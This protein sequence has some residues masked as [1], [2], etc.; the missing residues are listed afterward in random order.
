MASL[1]LLAPS[2]AEAL[3][4]QQVGGGFQQPIYVTSDPGDA[5]RLLVVER[6]GTIELVEAGVTSEFADLSSVVSCCEG[7]RGLLSIALDPNF[8]ATGRL[9]VDYTGK[10]VPGEIHVAELVAGP[11]RRTAS[12]STLKPLLAIP[13]PTES[14]H[15]GG[16]LQFGPDGNLYMSTGDGGGS[17][18]Q[19]HNAQNLKK[20]LGKI[21]RIHPNPNGPAPFYT[22]PAGNPFAASAGDYAPI[23]SYGLRN[24][25]RFSFDRLSGDMVIGDVGQ[26]AREEI[27]LA[28]SPR[29]GVVGG[30][31]ANY[32]W[33]CR[34][35]F[36]AGPATDPECATPPPAGLVE[37]V[38][39]YPHTPDPDLG[40]T[41]ERCA[42]IGGYVVRDRSLGDLYGRYLYG[43][44]CA[45]ELRS[46]DLAD[47][48][49]SDRSENVEATGLNSFGED[50]CGRIYVVEGSGHVYRLSGSTPAECATPAQVAAP[51]VATAK[52]ATPTFI[53][54]KPQRRRV[55]RGKRALLTVWV[56]PC[57][58]RKG[59]TVEL[60]RNGH[61][62][63]SRF[64]SRA[65]TARFLPQIRGGTTFVAA[66][67]E[68]RGYL[69]GR[70][71]HL[72]IRLAHRKRH[73]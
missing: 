65:C 39:D 29:P 30:A 20:P 31:G 19:L 46:L 56:S 13:H 52:P 22:V 2:G 49:A 32:G 25:F 14:N 45:G 40:G 64:L 10:E 5:G 24:P 54:I 16:Q 12:A 37:P 4:L 43:D 70:S 36:L 50:S 53:G 47:P 6:K 57:D 67:H 72:T 61:R 3:T 18:D 58:G 60:L 27:D 59:A 35:G 17:D 63:G 41:T 73:R 71:R 28:P 44:L 62:N 55:E 1:V 69:P 34:E 15:N 9:Y 51:S 38:F 48:S 7:E 33:N 21:L 11:D 68:G 23:W 42:I 66:T 26:D 8:E